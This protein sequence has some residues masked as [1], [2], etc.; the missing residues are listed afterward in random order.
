MY[1]NRFL[2]IV[3]VTNGANVASITIEDVVTIVAIGTIVVIGTIVTI[4]TNVAIGTIVWPMNHQ[5]LKWIVIGS[6]ESEF[7]GV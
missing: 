1:H 4:E 5:C 6:I 2:W 7:M 3:I